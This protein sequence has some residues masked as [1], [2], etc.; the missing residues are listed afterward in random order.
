M[1]DFE[2]FQ[3]SSHFP[4]KIVLYSLT[5]F[6]IEKRW[7]NVLWL[8]R[9]NLS[10][11]QTSTQ[12]YRKL[13]YQQKVFQEFD[14]LS[15][16]PRKIVLYSPTKFG[17]LKPWANIKSLRR[18]DLGFWQ[19]SKQIYRKYQYREKVFTESQALRCLPT[20]MILYSPTKFGILK[21][22]TNTW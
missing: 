9:F 22:W 13:Q 3:G 10:F 12:I 11:W 18:F 21:P 4:R 19:I 8:R 1:K 15:G 16:F 6:R 5:K 14:G 20:K 7:T 2:E 17:I